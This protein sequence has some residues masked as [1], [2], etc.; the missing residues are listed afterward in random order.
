[1]AA[2]SAARL[3]SPR[4]SA[5]DPVYLNDHLAGSVVGARLAER[6]R[7]RAAPEPRTLL[8]DL[9]FEIEEDRRTLV[10]VMDAVGARRH[11]V[12][13]AAAA[14]MGSLGRLKHD[15]PP[16]TPPGVRQLEDLEA[17]SLGI[18]G[19]RLLWTALQEGAEDPR[20]RGFDFAE[21]ERRAGDQRERLEPYRTALAAALP[22]AVNTVLA[23]RSA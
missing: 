8:Q 14:L 23:H 20:L 1:M 9:V 2:R 7:T 19:K 3:P 11:R 13:L 4:A 16:A 18:E 15:F 12:K 22:A 21:L 6:C 17:L 5:T 10:R